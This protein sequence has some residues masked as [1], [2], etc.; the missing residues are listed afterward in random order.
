MVDWFAISQVQD[1][2]FLI[3]PLIDKLFEE[4]SNAVL[5]RFLSIINDHF[6]KA[7]DVVLKRILSYVKGQKEYVSH[8]KS[9]FTRLSLPLT[10]IENFVIKIPLKV[11]VV[12]VWLKPLFLKLH[13][14]LSHRP[15]M[16]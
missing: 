16:F 1:W 8:Y 5:V 6:V 9:E 3:G 11:H 4:P 14:F 13:N 15:G 2:K 10:K 7:I 12:Y